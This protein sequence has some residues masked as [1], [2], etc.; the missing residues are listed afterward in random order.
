MKYLFLILFFFMSTSSFSQN[1]SSLIDDLDASL[2]KNDSS[3]YFLSKKIA[4]Y[5]K[6]SSPDTAILFLEKALNIAQNNNNE[7][8]IIKINL[9]KAQILSIKQEYD[10]AISVYFKVLNLISKNHANSFYANVLIKL[11]TCIYKSNFKNE[12]AKK[13]LF[14][15][16]EISDILNNNTTKIKIFNVLSIIYAEENKFDSAQFFNN[17]ALILSED[18]KNNDLQA[19]TYYY[20]A[21]VHTINDDYLAAIT[22]LKRS[23]TLVE[24]PILNA[25]YELFLATLY[26][27]MEHYPSASNVLN[28]VF[29]YYSQTNN[30]VGLITTYLHLSK[31]YQAQNLTNKSIKNAIEALKLSKETNIASLQ[32]ISYNFLSELY[33]KIQQIELALFN[34]KKYSTLR[35]SVFTESLNKEA[36]LMFS[37]YVLQ[38]KLKDQQLLNR[39]KQLQI[40]KNK[41]QSLII[42]ILGVSGILLIIVVFIL[43]RSYNLKTKS[44]QRLIQITEA[45]LE[46]ILIHDGENILECND[47]YLEISGFNREDIINHSIFTILPKKSIEIVKAKMNLKKTVFYQMQ[48]RKSDDSVFNAEL[49][50][51]PFKYKNTDAKVVSIKDLSEIRNIKDKLKTTKEQFKTLVEISPDGVVITDVAGKITYASPAFT[52]IFEYNDPDFFIGKELANF[53]NDTYKNKLKVDLSNIMFGNYDG[54]TEYNAIKNNNKEFYIECNGNAFKDVNDK[55]IGVF[56]IIRDVSERKIVENALIE[57]ESRFRGLFNNAKDA[58]MILNNNF[59]IV[60]VNPF[61]SEMLLYS[62]D[63]LLTMD[64]REFLPPEIRNIKYQNIIKNKNTL[65]SY[66]YIKNRKRIYIQISFSEMQYSTGKHYLLTIRDLTLFK[67]Q[68]ENLTRIATKLQESNATKDKMFSIIGHDLRGPI[69]SLRTMTEFIAENPD[70]FDEEELIEVIS[71]MR[72]TSSQTYELLENLLSWSKTQQNIHEYSPTEFNIVET[73]TNSVNFARN[74]ARNKDIEIDLL[75]DKEIN[76]IADENMIRAVMRNLLSNAIKFSKPNSKIT[77]KIIDDQNI[78]LIKVIDNGVG[79]SD[80][81]L[82]L[83]FKEASYF[84][85]YGTKNEKGTGLGLKLC[86]DFINKNNGKIWVESKINEGTTFSFTVKKA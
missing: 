82:Q 66:I 2:A 58:I 60:D 59:K 67:R 62:Y 27:K 1:I 38:L 50:S 16:N 46:G 68:E 6:Y 77:V 8:Q 61:T 81:N 22:H 56:M 45:T 84:T 25:K 65:E 20:L 3:F 71:S 29:I 5:Y 86:Q 32:I 37:N 10:E 83:I 31:Y 33:S 39:Q 80:E 49:L 64:F 40:L 73:A 24:D 51:K 74:I 85:T 11:S 15:A 53:V 54:V 36:E 57:S 30:K 19:E 12:V 69:G 42:Y 23:I 48:L 17:K 7:E 63:E 28:K 26:Y 72:D 55:V 70:E 43:L 35:D 14:Q 13:Y 47:K 18:I 34:Y 52:N 21:R 76:V 78:A 4:D 41:Q 75:F 9:R 44:E 79:I